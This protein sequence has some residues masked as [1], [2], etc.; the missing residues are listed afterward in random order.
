MKLLTSNAAIGVLLIL[1][2]LLFSSNSCN[3]EPI[4][5]SNCNPTVTVV[6]EITQF[7]TPDTFTIDPPLLIFR[8]N[9]VSNVCT[10]ENLK[11][12]AKFNIVAGGSNTVVSKL[13]VETSASSEYSIPLDIYNASGP[14]YQSDISVIL[15]TTL[16]PK[17]AGWVNFRV[18]ISWNTSTP[19]TTKEEL[20]AYANQYFSS[21]EI[22]T[23]YNQYKP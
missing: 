5:N 7:D 22:T 11:L 8:F 10:Y 19:Y 3:K 13:I 6:N 18:E 20:I 2:Y 4:G 21:F 23:T 16:G 14:Y 17:E 12:Y 15:V 1:S 9:G